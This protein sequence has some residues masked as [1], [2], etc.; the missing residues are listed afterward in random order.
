MAVVWHQAVV[1]VLEE[2]NVRG[3]EYNDCSL[4]TEMTAIHFPYAIA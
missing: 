3:G 2:A 1:Q 4:E